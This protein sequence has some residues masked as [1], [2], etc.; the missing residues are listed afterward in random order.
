MFFSPLLPCLAV[1]TLIKSPLVD[2]ILPLKLWL[3]S[4]QL[5]QNKI[6]AT[7]NASIHAAF[8]G[9]YFEQQLVLAQVGTDFLNN[10]FRKRTTS[11]RKMED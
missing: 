6:T 9:V 2:F 11:Y 8:R 7:A 5:C 4:S 3:L 1:I 10:I